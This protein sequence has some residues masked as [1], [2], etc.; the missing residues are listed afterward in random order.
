MSQMFRG[1]SIDSHVSLTK[2]LSFMKKGLFTLLL[3]G[4]SLACSAQYYYTAF[5]NI[6]RNPKDLNNDSEVTSALPAGW[7]VEY[8]GTATP[9][10]SDAIDIPFSFE[11][12]GQ[13]FSEF[14]VSTTGV[15]TFD[16]AASSV[17]GSDN[18]NLPSA[19]IPNNSICVWGL[20]SKLP[21]DR[22]ITKTFGE[23]GE[24]Q[25]WITFFAYEFPEAT[26]PI[27]DVIWSIVLEEG[28]NN[29]YIVD[30]RSSTLSAFS[31]SLT[32]GLQ[33]DEQD[34]LEV[35]GSP[36]ITNLSTNANTVANNTY[37]EFQQGA[38]PENDVQL[39]DVILEDPV[40]LTG[41]PVSISAQ[42][43]NLGAADIQ[44]LDMY[45]SINGG[46]PEASHFT[47][48]PDNGTITHHVP[49]VPTSEGAYSVRVV[50][51]LPNGEPD[52]TNDNEIFK[53]VNVIKTAPDR[54]SLIE[55]FTAHNC[56]P[57]AT[58]NPILDAVVDNNY[59]A[60]AHLKF[61]TVFLG[62]TD[63]RRLFNASDNLL[64][65][66]Y[67]GITAIPTAWIN[68]TTEK[69]SGSVNNS[70]VTI[71]DN[72][73][74]EVVVDIDHSFSGNQISVD[75]DFTPIGTEYA[76]DP[77]VAH[78][79]LVQNEL[80]YN[81]PTGTNGEQDYFYTMRYM[82]PNANG[83]ALPFDGT[84][85]TVS[86]TR[87]YNSIFDGS[88]M[89]VVAYVQNNAT[90]EILMATKSAGMY[91]CD[92]GAVINVDEVIVDN[93][94]CAAGT[95]GRIELK[96]SG[97]SSITVNW[98][99]GTTGLVAENLTAGEHVATITAPGGCTFE[100]PLRVQ[101]NEGPAVGLMADPISCSG[102]A[103]GQ[104]TVVST[105]DPSGYSYSWVGSTETSDTREDLGPGTYAVV[106]SD[107]SGCSKN[108]S[109]TLPEPMPLSATATEVSADVAGT[110]DGSADVS[111]TGGTFPY[112][113]SW[114]TTPEQ[115]T[116]LAT[117]L[118][119]GTYEV[120]VSDF[121]G[122]E[123]VQTVEV[124]GVVSIRETWAKIGLLSWDLSPNPASDFANITIELT[125]P[126][127]MQLSLYDLQGRLL[128]SQSVERAT[129]YQQNWDLSSLS[130]G[131]YSFQLQTEQ[132]QVQQRVIVK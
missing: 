33:F 30:Q 47:N 65:E 2:L 62:Q 56:G 81:S 55:S 20:S 80:Y 102:A 125:R 60:V 46:T 130:A 54:L 44:S 6:G 23:M 107:A 37:Y 95:D 61:T 104:I 123:S 5:E 32:L 57:C 43:V 13:S 28:T 64:R 19:E 27:A 117:G 7:T 122:C 11:F 103:D 16:M 14:K 71:A 35:A 52:P 99:N 85:T 68:G 88:L 86:G 42:Y 25:F 120:T 89:H 49:W 108:L 129:R 112:S 84:T 106:V 15:L 109:I 53:T 128:R 83:T 114:N 72:L 63:P 48:L 66:Q 8:P 79:A 119:T 3:V 77:V 126:Q 116:A 82:L 110:G 105:T 73:P 69:N 113:Y 51:L 92:N 38:R 58:N 31:A 22:I 74:G 100:V 21:T 87:A 76:D 101:A 12:N 93:T 90:G 39:L 40:T 50:L 24:Q 96:L 118:T 67:Y 18:T 1:I 91:F 115:T 10:W 97:S 41:G 4:M 59:P 45:Y 78:V 131:V 9:S 26:A 17:P 34:A 29:V 111:V 36:D 121:Y 70:D 98:D 127:T 124:S 94:S 132:G 75:V